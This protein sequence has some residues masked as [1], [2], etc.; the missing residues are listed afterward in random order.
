MYIA[1]IPNRG[2]PPAILLRESYRQDGKVKTRT[3]ANLSR[4]PEHKIEALSRALK[5]LPPRGALQVAFIIS[6]SLPHGHV[7]AVLG[8]LRQLRLEEVLDP[9]P[10]RQR[11]L[12]VAMVVARVLEPCS[13]L[14]LARGLR[15]ATGS[16]TLGQLCAVA[17]CDEDDLYAAMDWLVERQEMIE[18]RLAAQHLAEG[19]LVLYDVSS[20]AF[21][22]RTCPLGAIGHPRDGVKGRQQIV[23]G[24]LTTTAGIPVA[25]ETFRGN[26]VDPMTLGSQIRKLKERFHLTHVAFVGDRGMLTKARLSEELL[27]AGLDWITALRAPAIKALAEAGTIQLSLFDELDLAE[28]RHPDFAGERLIVCRNPQVAAERRRKREALL[29]GTEEELEQIAAATRRQRRPLRGTEQIALRVGRV[30]GH[31]KVGK[32]FALQIGEDF[33]SYQRRTDRIAAQAALDGLYVLRTSLPPEALPAPA[34]V[35]AY[36]QL[37]NVERV[38]RGFNSELEVRPIH[39]RRGDRVKAHLLLCMLA[40]Y[41]SWHMA[42]RL[43][44]LLFKED[45]PQGAEAQR[46]SPVAPATRSPAALAKAQRKRTAEEEPVHSFETLLQ[47][48]ATLAVN[49]IQP[50]GPEVSSFPLLTSPTPLQSRAFELLGVSPRLGFV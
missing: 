5:G 16:S 15:S 37:E 6:R 21:E 46:G 35:S 27:V 45:D 28:I 33:F 17:R 3:L 26:T 31:Y 29:A 1:R 30:I 47:D 14:A 9:V 40:Y 48:L 38:F 19:T 42:V 13:K 8:T 41:V 39:H 25:I 20:A 49:W 34:V 36:K 18:A 32:L 11:D 4:W 22:G 7:A 44:P 23:Y 12:V 2:S 10:S 50:A 43:A 24:L